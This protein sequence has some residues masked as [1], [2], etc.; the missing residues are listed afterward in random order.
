MNVLTLTIDLLEPLLITQPG[1][2]DPNSAVSLDHIPGSVLRGALIGRYL[3]DKDE[4]FNLLADSTAHRLFFSGQVR[5]LNA[6]PVTSS[7]LMRPAPL[8]WHQEKEEEHI[9]YDFAVEDDVELQH[10]QKIRGSYYYQNG[11]GVTLHNPD[12]QITIHTYRVNRSGQEKGKDSVFRYD[13]LAAGQTF[14]AIIIAN[15]SSDLDLLR[16]LLTPADFNIGGSHQAGYGRVHLAEVERTNWYDFLTEY[17]EEVEG[18]I[19]VT[20]LSDVLLR[21]SETGGYTADLDSL[22]NQ[23]HTAAYTAPQLVGGFN[24]KWGLPLPQAQAIRAGSVFVYDYDQSLF[25]RLIRLIQTGIGE[26]R[27]EGFGQ[28]GLNLWTESKFPKTEPLRRDPKSSISLNGDSAKLAVQMSERILRANLDKALLKTTAGLMTNARFNQIS[29]AQ[30]S[31]LRTIIRQAFGEADVTAGPDRVK[32]HLSALKKPA[33][34]Q[35]EKARVEGE[36]LLNWLETLLRDPKTVWI[37]LGVSGEQGPSIGQQQAQLND[38]LAA[39]YTLCL[40][41]QLLHRAAK[42]TAPKGGH[43]YE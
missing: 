22:L 34:T 19:I 28:I 17:D 12:R 35:F 15:N 11:E 7:E 37:K 23:N 41:D 3:Q 2:G 38:D 5:Y 29:N 30:L 21:D 39:E 10:P 33:R 43:H 25:T 4:E 40:I 26:R 31:R 8:A 9:L 18:K 13:A 1:G 42:P 24:R 14:G 6:W 32:A 27:V 20:C 16:S 36:P